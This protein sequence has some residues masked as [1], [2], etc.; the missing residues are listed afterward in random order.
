MP[1]FRLNHDRVRKE[2]IR[3]N[4]TYQ[5]LANRLMFKNRQTAYYIAT[6]GGVNYAGKL[7]KVFR[8][9]PR[10]LIISAS[11]RTP[12]GVRVVNGRVRKEA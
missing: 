1:L 7:A 11:F 12:R 4:L 9:D 3:N 2:M 5:E 10:D 8:C 6:K